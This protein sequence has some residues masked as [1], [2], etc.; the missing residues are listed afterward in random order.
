MS[1]KGKSARKSFSP[2]TNICANFHKYKSENYTS[3][4]IS[5]LK[6]FDLTY[7]RFQHP[8]IL[9]YT[10]LINTAS[11]ASVYFLL[12]IFNKAH[13]SFLLIKLLIWHTKKLFENRRITENSLVSLRESD[14]R[15]LAI[16]IEHRDLYDL[17]EK[18][19]SQRKCWVTFYFP[20][21]IFLYE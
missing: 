10:V 12:D 16:L 18:S 1:G 7:H 15:K 9:K 8:M 5:S 19:T 6:D 13:R 14:D 2:P 21:Q 20:L 17:D 4:T 3:D 11:K